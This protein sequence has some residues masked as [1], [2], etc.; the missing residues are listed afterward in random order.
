M[1]L[2]QAGQQ[3]AVADIALHEY[4]TCVAIQAGQIMQIAGVSQLVEIDHRLVMGG[5]PVEYKIGTNKACAACDKN[6]GK[7]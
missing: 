6:H 1:L 5:E 7:N 3:R 4:M 2:Q